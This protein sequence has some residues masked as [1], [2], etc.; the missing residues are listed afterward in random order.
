MSFY[1]NYSD[2]S[3]A[4]QAMIRMADYL[5]GNDSDN[6][7][8]DDDGREDSEAWTQPVLDAGLD[9]KKHKVFHHR[10][11]E[12]IRPPMP[13]IQQGEQL[14]DSG[15]TIVYRVTSPEHITY[16]RPL[17]LKVIVCKEPFRPPGPSS[18]ARRKALAEVR[19]MSAVRHSHIVCYVASFED[20]CI[21]SK[22]QRRTM[23]APGRS[24][25]TKVD[26]QIKRHILGIAMYPP[27]QWNLQEF[28]NEI[29]KIPS[30]QRTAV[31][32]S[33][34]DDQWVIPYMHTYFGCLGQAVAYLHKSS[35]QIRHKDIKP[36]NIVI[37]EFGYPVLTDFGLS[38]HFETGQHSDGPTGKTLKYADPEAMHET[39]RDER[40]DIFS[41][42][43]VYLE[44]ATVILGKPPMFAEEQLVDEAIGQFKYSESLHKLESYMSELNRV[45]EE[46]I[47]ADPARETSAR[48]ILDML[49][50]IRRMMDDDFSKRPYAHELYPK[51]RHLCDIHEHPGPC[52]SCEEERQTGRSVPSSQTRPS[53]PVLLRSISTLGSSSAPVVMSGNIIMMGRKNSV[54]SSQ[55]TCSPIEVDMSGI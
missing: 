24:T 51:F 46:L 32:A 15:S 49:P 28:M 18:N 1:S 37:D 2:V 4:S 10:N 30:S 3:H 20:Y 7:V 45:A 43:C 23:A 9:S 41:L 29:F 22:V 50:S 55:L 13:F 54:F 48:G 53:S 52:Q 47:A 26:Q 36:E 25:A 12:Y 5:N 35:V 44:I 42:G 31:T 34:G 14:G 19:N 8:W 38:K 33:Q 39:K 16:R 40:S 21:Q 27:A 17:A 6:F 11:K